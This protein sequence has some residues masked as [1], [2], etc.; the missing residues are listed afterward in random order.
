MTH[1]IVWVYH[2]PHS[3][4]C[5]CTPVYC[6]ICRRHASARLVLRTQRISLTAVFLRYS[7]VGLDSRLWKVLTGSLLKFFSKGQDVSLC[8]QRH[9][10]FAFLIGWCECKWNYARDAKL[11]GTLYYGLPWNPATRLLRSYD[12]G[13]KSAIVLSYIWLP[14]IKLFYIWLSYR[15]LS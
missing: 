1:W 6:R 14:Y 12:C 7:V 2:C 3:T 4:R 8:I 15:W 11:K 10:C 9:I 13:V 5:I